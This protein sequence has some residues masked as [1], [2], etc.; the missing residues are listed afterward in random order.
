MQGRVVY[1]LGSL[2]SLCCE[3]IKSPNWVLVQLVTCAANSQLCLLVLVSVDVRGDIN[4]AFFMHDERTRN[5]EEKLLWSWWIRGA[6]PK[7]TVLK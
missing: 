7:V 5:Q 3:C 6:Y 1:I 4:V 2:G